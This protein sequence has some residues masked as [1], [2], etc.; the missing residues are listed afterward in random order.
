MLQWDH[1]RRERELPGWNVP[2]VRRPRRV[3]M[4]PGQRVRT[5]PHVRSGRDVYEL[6]KPRECVLSGGR[7]RIRSDLRKRTLPRL[8]RDQSALLPRRRLRHRR[9]VLERIV[10]NVRNA[11]RVL[12]CGRRLFWRNVLRS[13]RHLPGLR[14]HRPSLLRRAVL[15]HR[16]H[17]LERFLPAMRSDRTDLLHGS[18]P[19]PLPVPGRE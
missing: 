18:N 11:R 8:W 3:A 6:R 4:L 13:V 19:V 14:E 5:W 15:R 1:L 17:V 12:L 16:Q 7:L 9:D 10:P 2:G